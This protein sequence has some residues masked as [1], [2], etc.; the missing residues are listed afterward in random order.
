MDNTNF[1][2]NEANRIFNLLFIFDLLFILNYNN[3]DIH[4][5]IK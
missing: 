4:V 1:N 3:K 2:N 5:Y